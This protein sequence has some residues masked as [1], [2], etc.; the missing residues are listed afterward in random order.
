MK[1]PDADF[2]YGLSPSIAVNQKTISFNPRST[3][4]TLTEAYDYLRLLYAKLGEAHCPTHKKVLSS[5]TEEEIAGDIASLLKKEGLMILSPIARGKKGEFTKELKNCLKLGFDK[6]RINGKWYDIKKAPK[7]EKRKDHYIE[8]LVDKLTAKDKSRLSSSLSLAFNLSKPFVMVESLSKS[9]DFKKTYSLELSCPLCNYSFVELEAKLFSFNSEKGACEECNGTGINYVEYYEEDEE[10]AEEAVEETCE[11]CQGKRLKEEAL[12]VKIKNK[13]I[14]TLASMNIKHL[15]SFLEK[16]SYQ[17]SKKIIFERIKKPLL[18]QLNF[19]SKL[20]LDYLDLNRSLRSLSGGEAQRARLSSQL[21]SP[22][23]GVIYV[24]DEPSIGLHPQDHDKIL[25]AIKKIRDRGNTVIIVEHDEASIYEADRVIDM[26]PGAGRLGGYIIA[27]GSVEEIKKNKNSLTGLYL[28]KKKSIPSYESRF[29][30]KN[31]KLKLKNLTINNLKDVS[32]DLP[33]GCLV[34]VS[35]VSGSGKS[36]LINQS[37][38]PLVLNSLN[39]DQDSKKIGGLENVKK[40]I[41]VSQKPIGKTPRSNPATYIGLFQMIR[42]F[43]AGL[44]MAK[45]RGFQAKDFSFNVPGGRCEECKGSG[46]IKLEM[47]FLPDVWTTCS[48]CFGKRYT[49]DILNVR[50]KEKNIY[51]ILNMTVEQACEFFKNHPYIYRHLV[52]LN[53]VGLSYIRLGQSSVTLSGGEAQRVKLAKELAKKSNSKSLYLLD[54]PTT[55]LHFQDV[56][57][58]IAILRRLAQD[59]KTVIVIEHHLDVLKACDYVIDMGPGAGEDGGEVVA[60]GTPKQI[61]QNKK[62][63][64]GKFLKELF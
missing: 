11:K 50:Y 62:S 32:V 31:P 47:R 38:Y 2:I 39:G 48:V 44:P 30:K 23:V 61:T 27:E 9:D 4:G 6:A 19:L 40:I 53:D 7:L 43:F 56:E 51:D 18:E 20:S 58:L 25:N 42:N 64:T 26:G 49:P 12:L 52:F 46:A 59:G 36:S 28:S 21:A 57:K 33:L 3:L 55:G 45:M 22:V 24:L 13:D 16:L 37:L 1:K 15:K 8:I 17:G 5:Q 41:Q 14:S 10:D 34:G 35:G 54:E 63:I 60:E 29:S